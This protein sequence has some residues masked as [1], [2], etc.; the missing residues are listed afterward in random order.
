MN[1]FSLF[2]I[3]TVLT[4]LFAANTTVAAVPAVDAKGVAAIVT[5]P[6]SATG[7]VI[8]ATAY[9]SDK[10]VF[11]ISGILQAALAA[12][13]TAISK[14]PLNTEL[15]IKVR[16]N[17]RLVADIKSKVLSFLGAAVNPNNAGL[18]KIISVEYAIAVCPKSP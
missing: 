1:K 17:P 18:I 2:T 11:S 12:D 9:H 13:Q 15:D 14:L 16:D 7:A 8:P 6:I 10:I 5:C 3:F 4:G